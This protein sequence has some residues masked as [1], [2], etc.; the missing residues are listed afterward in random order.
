MEYPSKKFK[1][2]REALFVM[3]LRTPTKKLLKLPIFN[4]MYFI[5]FSHHYSCATVVNV[6]IIFNNSQTSNPKGLQS[7]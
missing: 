7:L 2:P 3:A 4:S 1:H 5:R 6:S